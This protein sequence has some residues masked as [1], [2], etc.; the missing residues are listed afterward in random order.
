MIYRVLSMTVKPGKMPQA[1]Q[2]LLDV[3]AHVMSNYPHKA[4]V[5]SNFS[6]RKNRLHFV[7]YH[8]SLGTMEKVFSAFENDKQGKAL[9]DKFPEVFEND[10]EI[11]FYTVES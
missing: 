9:M 4:E 3:A 8:E 6:G 10:R 11:S 5:L 2:L 1:R 7:G